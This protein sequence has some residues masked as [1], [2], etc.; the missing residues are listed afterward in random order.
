M[1]KKVVKNVNKKK[2]VNGYEMPE[3]IPKG[4]V[5]TDI[6]KQRWIIGTSIGVGGFGEIYTG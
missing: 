3:P 2:K 4:E 5:L 1:S 6:G